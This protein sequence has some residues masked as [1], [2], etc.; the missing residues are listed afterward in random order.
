MDDKLIDNDDGTDS[1]ERDL[2]DSTQGMTEIALGLEYS[3]CLDSGATLFLRASAEW[4]NWFNYSS[5]F[6]DVDG[7]GG[8]GE[9]FGGQSDVGFG[10][11]V[12]SAGLIY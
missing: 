11:Y 12:L 9:A 10:G 5:S 8:S 3:E 2:L 6:E 4:Q 7:G 1:Q